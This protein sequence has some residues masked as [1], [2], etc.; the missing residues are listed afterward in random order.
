MPPATDAFGLVGTV[1]EGKYRIDAVVDYLPGPLDIPPAEGLE[2]G[3]D[4]K[5]VYA[6]E[7][8]SGI[9]TLNTKLLRDDAL[10]DVEPSI[11]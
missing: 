5:I 3:S 4:N 8:G 1:L 9:N 7:P 6:L 10:T 11:R 2:P